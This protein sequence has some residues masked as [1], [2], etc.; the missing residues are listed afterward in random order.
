M[1]FSENPERNTAIIWFVISAG[2]L[3]LAIA[4]AVMT[5]SPHISFARFFIPLALACLSFL[6]IIIG[7][8]LLWSARRADAL[9]NGHELLLHWTY[10]FDEIVPYLDDEQKRLKKVRTV[11]LF[12]CALILGMGMLFCFTKNG[13]DY[14]AVGE[15]VGLLLLTIL[16]LYA[17]LPAMGYGISNATEFYLGKNSALFGGRF[18]IWGMWGGSLQRVEYREGK[19]AMLTISYSFVA[20]GGPQVIH[21]RIPVPHGRERETKEVVGPY[22]SKTEMLDNAYRQRGI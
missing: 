2:S 5:F 22:L 18:H 19:P 7:F 16:F 12:F 6:G 9:I 20:Q 11:V 17:G 14:G 8:A 21:L 1:R 13:V 15:Y 10:R 4:I 3:F